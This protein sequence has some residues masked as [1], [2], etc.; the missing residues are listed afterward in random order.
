[1]NEFRAGEALAFAGSHIHRMH[2]D[3]G[4]VTIHV[5]SP[6]IKRIGSYDVI[7]GVLLRTSGSPDDESPATPELDAAL[8]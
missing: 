8:S 4:S 5:Y 1:V 6:P 3:P 7:D 2:H